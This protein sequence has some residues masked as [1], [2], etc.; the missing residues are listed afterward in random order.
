M[1][2]VCVCVCVCESLSHVQLFATPWTVAHQAPLFMAF[3]RQ[4]YWSGLPF[5]SLGDLPNSGI[6]PESPALQ[7]DS[8]PSEPPGKPHRWW[9]GGIGSVCRVYW[10]YS[11]LEICNHHG[12]LLGWSLKD[13]TKIWYF[14]VIE[15]GGVLDV[16]TG[17]TFFQQKIRYFFPLKNC[18]D[19]DCGR[20]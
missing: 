12:I 20:D 7:T 19:G 4:E 3:S 18:I 17:V 10:T 5:P 2:C 6:E 1:I 15:N 8:L 11:I 9:E 13:C 14:R 16:W